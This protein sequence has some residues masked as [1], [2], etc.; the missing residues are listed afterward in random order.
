MDLGDFRDQP[1][2]V[3]MDGG[4][5]TQSVTSRGLEVRGIRFKD[6][7]ASIHVTNGFVCPL[8]RGPQDGGGDSEERVGEHVQP[9]LDLC[10]VSSETMPVH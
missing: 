1:G 5:M 7:A 8:V 6:T 2:M 4:A 3:E 10:C 9:G